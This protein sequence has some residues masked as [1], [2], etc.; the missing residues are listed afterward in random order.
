MRK[1]DD[2]LKVIVP[3]FSSNLM[4][5]A[6]SKQFERFCYIL[7]QVALKKHLTHEGIIEIAK[8]AE[9]MNAR[10]SRSDLIRILREHTPRS[11][12]IEI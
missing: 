7:S 8:I 4:R 1:Q 2:L 9:K 6:K 12:E 5:T 10:K 11:Q 3:F